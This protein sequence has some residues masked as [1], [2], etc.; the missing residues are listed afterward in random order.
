MRIL[1]VDD[2][3]ELTVPLSRVL[4]REGYTVEA[5]YEGKSG[6]EMATV[7]NY[8]LLILDWMLPGKT[9]LRYAKNYAAKEKLHQFFS[10]PPKIP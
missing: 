7:G 3:V 8:D 10:S 6:S 5:A 9:G 1:L 2:E 4:T